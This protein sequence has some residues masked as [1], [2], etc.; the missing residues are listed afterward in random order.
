MKQLQRPPS[1]LVDI[2]RMTQPIA[3]SPYV[4]LD[5]SQPTISASHYFLVV[6]R[7]KWRILCFIATCLLV[8]FLV[9]SRLTPIYEAT[10]R[11]DVDRRVPSAIIGQEASQ[12]VSSEDADQFMTTQIE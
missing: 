9:S 8:T 12:A 11:I 4:E 6:Y 7:Q 10:A 1:E 3:V 5:T 2:R